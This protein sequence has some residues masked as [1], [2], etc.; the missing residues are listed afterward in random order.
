MATQSVMYRNQELSTHERSQSLQTASTTTKKK[1]KSSEEDVETQAVFPFV[2]PEVLSLN[3]LLSLNSTSPV[4]SCIRHSSKTAKY[5]GR[6][7]RKLFGN[8]LESVEVEV[9]ET[10]KIIRLKADRQAIRA[11]AEEKATLTKKFIEQKHQRSPEIMIPLRSHSVWEKMSVRLS[12]TILGRPVPK[13]KWYKNGVELK[14]SVCP[15][16]YT[17]HNQYGLH[18]LDINRCNLDDT[19][20]YRIVAVN[21]LGEASSYAT[22]LVKSHEDMYCGSQSMKDVAPDTRV[23]ADFDV[24]FKAL[25]PREGETLTLACTFSSELLEHQE[26]LAWFKDGIPLK[27]TKWLQLH[28]SPRLASLKISHIYKE[29]EGLYSIHLPTHTGVKCHNAYIYVRDAV[30]DE[31][32]VPGSPLDVQCTDIN[33]DYVFLTWK[34]PSADGGSPVTGYYVERCERGTAEWVQC[35]DEPHKLCRFPLQGLTNGK[36]YYFRVRAVNKVGI[37]RP[38]MKTEPVTISDPLEAGRI[39][40]IDLDHGKQITVTKDEIEGDIR[41]PLPP[42]QVQ[43]S[44]VS[45]SYIVLNWMEPDPRGREPLNYYVEK[46]EAGSGRW[47]MANFEI[48]VSSPRFPVFGLNKDKSYQFRVKSVNKYGVSEPSLPS[49][50]IHLR[51]TFVCPPPPRDVVACRNTNTSVVLQWKCP[52]TQEEIGG[53]YMYSRQAGSNEWVT[54]NNKPV[55]CT[56]FTVDGLL[57]QKEY[58]FRVKAVNTAGTSEFSEESEPILVKAA[59]STP[60]PP[61]DIAL[62][63]CGRND[64]VIGWKVPKFTGAAEIQGYFLDQCDVSDQMW[65]EV[66]IKPHV[67]RVFKIKNLQEGHFYQFR[68]MA[69]NA[70]GV[71]AP[72]KPSNPFLC[73]EWTMAQP[74]PPYDVVCREVRENSLVLIWE[75]PIYTGQSPVTGYLIETRK[76]GSEVWT[77]VTTEQTQKTWLKVSDLESG[78]TYA[79]RVS[80]V[81]SAGAGEFSMPSQDV[82]IET[83][84]GLKDIEI[85][86]DEDGFIFLSFQTP[87]TSDSSQAQWMKNYKD[88]L[89]AGRVQKVAEGNRSKLV[90]KN[91]SEDDLGLYTVEMLDADGFS[92]SYDFTKEDLERML[93]LSWDVRNPLIGMKS[94][95]AVDVLDNGTVR[96]W[97]QVEKL[98]PSAE[99]KLIFNDK[100]LS[101]TPARKINFDRANGLL[102]IL[103]DDFSEADEGSYTAQLKDGRAKNQFTLVLIDECFRKTLAKSKFNRHDWKRKMGPYFLEPLSWKITD[104]CELLISCKA[105][106]LKKESILKWF[107]DRKELSDFHFNPQDG[108]SSLLLKE[109][110]KVHMGEYKTVLS[111]TRGEDTSLLNLGDED[112][113]MVLKELCR[114]AALSASGLKIQSTADGFQLYCSLKY[115]LEDIKTNWRLKEKKLEDDK[116]IKKGSSIHKVWIDIF[117]PTEADKGKYVL[118]LCD[119]KQTYLRTLDLSGHVFDE[120]FEEYQRLRQAAIAEKNRAKVTKGL[121]DVVAI[122]ED[123]TLCLT[124]GF[125]GDPIPEINWTKNDKQIIVGDQYKIINDSN[126]SAITINKVSSD[127]SGKYT[128][129]VKNKYGT[130]EATVTVSVYKHGETPIEGVLLI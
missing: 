71:G 33:K 43:A 60:S 16:K 46:A 54:I 44:E 121:P 24:T 31:A 6:Q 83:K 11:K 105:T 75:P 17:I 14:P 18:M 3:E 62:L 19:A 104:D 93:K 73:R 76:A 34:P 7:K 116:R 99:L 15:G 109:V 78:Q 98:S 129:H 124:C 38:S 126:S 9:I 29:D 27:E 45:G 35:N 36:T 55:T 91:P 97:L 57:P 74:G 30:A 85:G 108:Q 94:D 110:T 82:C 59:I 100:E 111:D 58:T 89:D 8:E 128:I 81:N 125:A 20:E 90:F 120:A 88:D 37:S 28:T 80:A 23:E 21:G 41:I 61:L 4:K 67:T 103:I 26:C 32:G 52:Q 117:N 42:T 68:A 119:D 22:V 40:V 13:V 5:Q 79:F 123:K 63:S 86:V 102:E 56:R 50:P 106:N 72:S 51:D 101:S 130:E 39:M 70:A 48:P 65:Q 96:L 47:Q 84:A 1:F 10:N 92:S 114:V 115:Y 122:M 77:A 113:K 53:Y 87:E 64:M 95:W 69:V 66:N 112:F 49:E 118:E 127:D 12:C 25:F 107:K 2:S